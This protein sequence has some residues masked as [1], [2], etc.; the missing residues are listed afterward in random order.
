MIEDVK[1]QSRIEAYNSLG[2]TTKNIV[3]KNKQMAKD[4]R[5]HKKVV[6]LKLSSFYISP[7]YQYAFIILS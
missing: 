6:T 5:F 1:R 4:L 3:E 7:R 2:A